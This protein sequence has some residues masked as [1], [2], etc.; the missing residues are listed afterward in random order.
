MATEYCLP[1]GFH[2]ELPELSHL[3]LRVQAAEQLLQREGELVP[4]QVNGE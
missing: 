3:G 2:A 1:P 4:G